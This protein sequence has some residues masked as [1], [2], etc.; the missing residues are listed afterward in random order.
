MQVMTHKELSANHFKHDRNLFPGVYWSSIRVD[1]TIDQCQIKRV[2]QE[3]VQNIVG[4]YN[5]AY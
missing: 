2:K 1:T 3:P 4:A 5:L